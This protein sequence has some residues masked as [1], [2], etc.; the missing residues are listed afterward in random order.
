MRTDTHTTIRMGFI[1]LLDASAVI[2]ARE[3][4]FAAAQGIDFR[5]NRE[6]SWANVRDR[7]AIG[8]FDAAHMLA[9][10]PVATALGLSPLPVALTVPVALGLGGNAVTVSV[11]LWHEL[12]RS[13]A[14][15]TGD[16]KA[17]GAALR[18][19]VEKRR[20]AGLQPLLFAVVHPFSSHNFELRYWLSSC[21]I[22]PGRDIAL[23]ITP[24]P[25]MSDALA[26]GR[27]DGYCVGEPWNSVAIMRGV[28]RIA[29]TKS[30]IW[31]LSPEKVVACRSEWAQ[32]NPR[33]VRKLVRAI[34][35]AALWCDRPE[36]HEELAQVLSRPEY[37][38][39][40]PAMLLPGLSNVIAIGD[41]GPAAVEDF[42]TFSRAAATRPR[43][44]DAFWFYEQM[45]RW[46][47]VELSGE[48]AAAV[49][50]VFAADI[51]AEA[52]GIPPEP[53]ETDRLVGGF[54]DGRSFDADVLR[55]DAKAAR[56]KGISTLP[57][58]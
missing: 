40:P 1:P 18:S 11:E 13:G 33:V 2:A 45:A 25:F 12:A 51:H 42:M 8:H 35:E 41:A 53:A 19:V 21:G 44:A 17:V 47:Y 56:G 20:N 50:T 22:E 34:H 16:P 29:T 14:P 28:G 15:S 49:E 6:T 37:L 24:P 10:L 46:G 55:Q 27:I 9:P 43:R 36:N 26:A 31:G 7:L 30:Q 32:E 48:G 38:G 54:F 58:D 23:A 39:L 52:T 3:M 4:G 5:L 57:V